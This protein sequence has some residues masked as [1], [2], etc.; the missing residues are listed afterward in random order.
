MTLGILMGS[1]RLP[2]AGTGVEVQVPDLRF[3]TPSALPVRVAVDGAPVLVLARHGT[4][5]QIAPHRINYR[6]NVEALHRLGVTRI[7]ALNTVGGITSDARTGRL[8]VPHQLVDYTWGR[9]HTFFDDEVVHAD[10][11]EPFDAAL[12]SALIAAGRAAGL[13]IGERGTYGCTQG[14]RFETVAEIDRMARDG[15]TLVGM[16][17]MPEAALARELGIRYAMLSLVVNPAAGRAADPFD[18]DAIR[19]VIAAGAD[20]ME[21]VLRALL[22]A[23][24]SEPH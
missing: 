22:Q 24:A 23:L 2:V 3:G 21:Q 15:C 11:A 19:R 16:T 13:D 5:H 18:L 6:A 12:R 14:P 8:I 9:A 1:G 4:P 17:G 20:S 7:V 10:F